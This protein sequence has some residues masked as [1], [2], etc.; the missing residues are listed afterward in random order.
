MRWLG[1]ADFPHERCRIRGAWRFSEKGGSLRR[2][3]DTLREFVWAFPKAQE[4][5]P[6]RSHRAIFLRRDGRQGGSLSFKDPLQDEFPKTSSAVREEKSSDNSY[7][8][9]QGVS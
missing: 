7:E 4:E 6:K 5:R 3:R 1:E 8:N 9:V 2:H